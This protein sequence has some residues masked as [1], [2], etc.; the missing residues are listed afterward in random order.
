[1][2]DLAYSGPCNLGEHE[3]C[4]G[5]VHVQGGNPAY[6]PC[7]CKC[8]KDKRGEELALWLAGQIEQTV[9]QPGGPFAALR[10]MPV[11]LSAADV[12]QI[13]QYIANG[14][15]ADAQKEILDA[16]SHPLR[17]QEPEGYNRER[18]NVAAYPFVASADD[19]EAAP[20][21]WFSAGWEWE[22]FAIQARHGTLLPETRE[23]VMEKGTIWVNGQEY[24]Y[25][26][27]PTDDPAKLA[28]IE[29]AVR[30]GIE[31]MQAAARRFRE[32]QPS[33]TR[34][35]YLHVVPS[36]DPEDDGEPEATPGSGEDDDGPSGPASA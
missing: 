12:E 19:E 33:K 2:Y 14:Q 30:T 15:I 4:N 23:V 7:H 5:F 34:P 29:A 17:R 13:H 11:H 36:A 6:K 24:D 21:E 18:L 27:E 9:N 20:P 26:F 8:H 3:E 31:D 35:N 25:L 1:M 32:S 10:R 28:M 22:A 16:M